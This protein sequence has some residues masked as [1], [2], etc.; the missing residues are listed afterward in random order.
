MP[1]AVGDEQHGGRPGKLMNT[2]ISVRKCSKFK[3][4]NSL[5]FPEELIRDESSEQRGEGGEEGKGVV[6]DGG[7]VLVEA[8]LV[9]E[10]QD[11]EACDLAQYI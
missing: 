1:G 7:K 9:L 6:D 2:E 4:S 10:V 8:K 11:Q 5:V 3:N